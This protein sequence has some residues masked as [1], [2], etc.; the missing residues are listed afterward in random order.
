LTAPALRAQR[1][2]W[3]S[4]LCEFRALR[5]ASVAHCFSVPGAYSNP[6]GVSPSLSPVELLSPAIPAPPPRHRV[7]A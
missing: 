1:E 3:A 6:L 2:G 5:V 7:M 4:S